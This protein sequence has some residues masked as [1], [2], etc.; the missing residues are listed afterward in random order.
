MQR[1]M[2]H[3]RFTLTGEWRPINEKEIYNHLIK[4]AGHDPVSFYKEL[5]GEYS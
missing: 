5:R 4:R 2:V 3:K 1:E